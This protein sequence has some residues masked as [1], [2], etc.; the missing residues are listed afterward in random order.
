MMRKLDPDQEV[1][2][3]KGNQEMLEKEKALR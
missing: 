2:E 1:K 3:G